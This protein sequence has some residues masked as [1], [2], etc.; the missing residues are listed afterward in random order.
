MT[1]QKDAETVSDVSCFNC[2]KP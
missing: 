1:M 2:M